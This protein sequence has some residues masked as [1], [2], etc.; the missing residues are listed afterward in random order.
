MVA[1]FDHRG[2][3]LDT[4]NLFVDQPLAGRTVLDL[5]NQSDHW[6]RGVY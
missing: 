2:L 3:W 6:V 1:V 4:S 5:R